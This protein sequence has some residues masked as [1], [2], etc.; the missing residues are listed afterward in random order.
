M[1][2]ADAPVKGQLMRLGCV[3]DVAF[4]AG[5]F[6]SADATLLLKLNLSV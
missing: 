5:R 6:R 4:Y 1:G 3:Y 2:G